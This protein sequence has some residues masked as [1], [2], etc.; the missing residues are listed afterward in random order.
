MG[1]AVVEELL[2]V[3][4]RVALLG[5]EG[6]EVSGRILGDLEGAKVGTRGSARLVCDFS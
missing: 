4:V 3:G 1:E 2:L 5:V 6:E